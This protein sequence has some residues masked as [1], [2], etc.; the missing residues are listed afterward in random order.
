MR[1]TIKFLS[2]VIV[3]FHA[4]FS[5]LVYLYAETCVVDSNKIKSPEKN[6]FHVI[7]NMIDGAI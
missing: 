6:L 7:P 4:L 1:F 2:I 5:I 3:N